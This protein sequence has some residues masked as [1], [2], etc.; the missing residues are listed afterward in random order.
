[1]GT[2]ADMMVREQD[3]VAI[4]EEGME[5]LPYSWRPGIRAFLES[6]F[7]MGTANMSSK[8][9]Q[10][11]GILNVRDSKDGQ[12]GAY[13]LLTSPSL[14][15]AKSM[16]EKFEIPRSNATRSAG[17][18]FFSKSKAVGV[19]PYPSFSLSGK[20]TAVTLPPRL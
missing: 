10:M 17:A 15:K 8:V 4:I 16:L 9:Q 19:M 3:N 1:L 14:A 5:A 7:F 12:P 6:D 2:I 20:Y 18:C 13:R 11:I